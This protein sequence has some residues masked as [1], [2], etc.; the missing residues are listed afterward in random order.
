MKRFT[1]GQKGFT[2]IELLIVIIII[3]IL[4]AIAIPMYLNMRVRAKDSS[5]KEGAHSVLVGV[6]SW[7]TD[8]NDLYPAQ[9]ETFETFLASQVDSWPKDPFSSAG[10]G[11]ANGTNTAVGAGNLVYT[12]IDDASNHHID[13]NLAGV[14]HDGA[15]PGVFVVHGATPAAPPATP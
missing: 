15:D 14:L 3:G 9:T 4:A 11:M 6:Q 12:A 1:K 7:A 5:V 8:N 13:F 10:D 2:L